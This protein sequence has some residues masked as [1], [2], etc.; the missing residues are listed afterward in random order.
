MET[1]RCQRKTNPFDG[2]QLKFNIVLL[3]GL[4][5]ECKI[6]YRNVG[7]Y[8]YTGGTHVYFITEKNNN[9]CIIYMYI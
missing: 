6:L 5:Q 7:I 4:P 3:R 2:A 9:S 8:L 1:V